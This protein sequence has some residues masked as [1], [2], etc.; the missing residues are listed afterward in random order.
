MMRNIVE[1]DPAQQAM[2]GAWSEKAIESFDG[3]CEYDE[4]LPD[5]AWLP[6]GAIVGFLVLLAAWVITAAWGALGKPDYE[7]AIAL[8]AA[9]AAVAGVA[10]GIRRAR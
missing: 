3:G 6:V 8:V 10:Y 1:H 5:I 9:A 7:T 4:P 2:P